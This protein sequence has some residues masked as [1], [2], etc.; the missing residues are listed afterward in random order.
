[1]IFHANGNQS[2][3]GTAIFIFDRIGFK[4]KTVIRDKECHYIMTKVSI[5]EVISI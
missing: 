4:I 2:N 1:M 5:Q 3:S